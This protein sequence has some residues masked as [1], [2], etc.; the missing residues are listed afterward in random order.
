MGNRAYDLMQSGKTV[1]F[2]FEEAIGFMCGT[3][4]LDKDGV[5]AAVKM[6]ELI[7]QLNQQGLT[8]NDKLNEIYEK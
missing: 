2:A 3:L 6:G 1:L 4:V 7:V 5:G 8:I